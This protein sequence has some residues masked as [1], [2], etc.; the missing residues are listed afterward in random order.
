MI[1]ALAIYVCVVGLVLWLV[2]AA[3][4]HVDR[5]CE[6]T[7]DPVTFKT[8]NVVRDVGLYGTFGNDRWP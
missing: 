2:L 1:V 3:P 8:I 4:D 7:E 5:W 6:G